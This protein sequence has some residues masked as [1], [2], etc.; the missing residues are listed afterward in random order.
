MIASRWSF[1]PIG[2]KLFYAICLTFIS[3]LFYFDHSNLPLLFNRPH[4]YTALSI[5]SIKWK[6]QATSFSNETK[7]RWKAIAKFLV[8]NQWHRC[9]LCK[10]LVTRIKNATKQNRKA[11]NKFLVPEE[12][13]GESPSLI[14]CIYA[15]WN[16][17]E[18]LHKVI[19]LHN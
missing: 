3:Y 5:P 9:N 18:W 6:W 8:T 12:Q 1:C 15:T 2:K 11:S 16:C 14:F 19:D 13:H 7:Q 17:Q 10:C 4:N